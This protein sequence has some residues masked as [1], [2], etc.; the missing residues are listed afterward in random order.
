PYDL[1]LMLKI[2]ILQRLYNIGSY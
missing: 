1:V 2:L